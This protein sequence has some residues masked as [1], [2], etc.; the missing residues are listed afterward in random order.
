MRFNAKEIPPL[1]LF[2]EL[3]GS[4]NTM[5]NLMGMGLSRTA[6]AIFVPH[7]INSNMKREEIISWLNRNNIYALGLPQSVLA[8]I[9]QI[10]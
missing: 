5:V 4:T 10:R 1:H 3:G 2:M 7:L 9:E 8:E 6:A